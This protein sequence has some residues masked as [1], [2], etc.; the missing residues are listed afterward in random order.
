MSPRF[1]PSKM[2]H[3]GKTK[4]SGMWT[5]RIASLCLLGSVAV[6]GAT[7]EQLDFFEQRIRPVLANECYECHGPEKQKGGLRLDFRDGLLKGGDTGPALVPGNSKTS[8]LIQSIRHE[9]ADSE[10]PKKRPK[11]PDA[12]IADFAGWV[13]QGAL[14]P[15]DQPAPITTVSKAAEWGSTFEAR[16]DWW[17]FKP[18]RRS[19]V[20]AVKNAGW[21]DQPVDRF[22]LAKMEEHGLE[23]ASVADRRTLIRRVTYAL[24]GLPPTTEEIHRFL[25][26]AA[27]DAYLKVVDRL[28]ASP[29]FG[30]HWARHWMDLVRFAET[31]GSEGD[32]EIPNAWRYRDYLVRAFNADVPWDQLI[33][34]HLAGDLLAKPRLNDTEGIN[35]SL[36]GLAHFRLVEHGYNPVDTLD[37][38]VKTIDSQ[39]DV[40][41][42]AFQGLTVSCARCH[43]HKFDPIGQRDYYALQGVFGSVRPTQLTFDQPERLRVHRHELEALKAEIK[44]GL[45]EAWE[46]FAHRLTEDL[47]AR[48]RY[49]ATN[50][51]SIPGDDFRDRIGRLQQRV[52]EIDNLGRESVL[53][54]RGVTNANQSSVRPVAAWTFDG[55]ARDSVGGLAGELVGGAFV[56]DGRLI[57][58]GKEAYLRTAP[59]EHPLREKTLEVWAAPANLDQRGGGV[60][61]VES[62]DGSVFDSIVFAEK[63]PRRWMAGSEGFRRSRNLEGPDET[64][65]AGSLVHLVAVYR[66]SNSIAL[67]RDG[68]AYGAAYTASGEG[69]KLREFGAASARVLLGMRHT[70][71][72]S[73]FFAGEIEEARLYDRALEPDEVAASF[74][75]GPGLISP[76][77]ISQALTPDQRTVREGRLAEIAELRRVM[78]TRYPDYAERDA[79]RIRRNS[80]FGVAAKDGSH[81]LGV[82]SRLATNS[83]GSFPGE[84]RAM[85]AKR[86]EELAERR[87]FN[88]DTFRAAWDF[89]G[90]GSDGWF[91]YGPNPP[92]VAARPGEFTVQPEGDRILAGLLPAGVFSHRLSER[93]NGVFASPRFKVSSDRISVRVVGGKGARVRLIT[94]NYPIGQGNIFPQANLNS[95][96]PTWITLDTAYRR[97][98]M[99]YLELAT[100]EDV[101]SRDRS[102]A[103]PGGRSF[104]GVERVVF[105]DGKQPPADEG[106]A[107][108]VLFQG[109]P[110]AS[111]EDLAKRIGDR[112]VHAIEAWRRDSLSEGDR[113][114]LDAFI[115][116]GQL[117]G[118]LVDLPSV[119][120][121][122]LEYR[123][124]EGE[125]PLPR[126]VPGVVE[127]TAYDA[128]L[129][130][131]GDHRKPMDPVPRGY[132][133]LIDSHPYATSRSGR[134][135]LANDIVDPANPLTS[136][137]MVNRIWHCLF[138]RG[139][140]GT[141]D[142]FGR[143][144]EEPSHPEL[145]DFLAGHFIEHGWSGKELIRFLVTT[146]AYQLSSV[147]SE[148]SGQV[149]PA[150]EWLSHAR[151]RRLE[152]ESIRDSL[153]AISGRLDSTMFGPGA[154][155]LAM[156]SE[157]RRRSVYL[158]VKR[159]FPSPFLETFDAPKPFTTLG[160]RDAT[161]VP[162][163][164]LALLNDPFVVEQAARWAV[165]MLGAEL[166]PD[167][168]VQRMFEIAF[169]RPAGDAE[170]A[171]CRT[172]LDDLAKDHHGGEAELV[173]RD[174]GQSLFNLKE[175][176]YLR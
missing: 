8:L 14:D 78:A 31:H 137:V 95:D 165:S 171:L 109:G 90:K 6:H 77:A 19:A 75:A 44:S 79:E 102:P 108:T 172:Y 136:R 25:N 141:V 89:A 153:L 97:D 162:A 54:T 128:P 12:V 110:P 123:G 16:K 41:T 146:R 160:Q 63:E 134:L 39:I 60:L 2:Q 11:L 33:R 117:P 51:P 159:N 92:E 105:H 66:T 17:S 121:N 166:D 124:L 7:P 30:E 151:V 61:T 9:I 24:T 112:L 48:L 101:T 68:V 125:I 46:N 58:D 22:L 50:S 52:A 116:S 43:D 154:D 4:A 87:K 67:F 62:K 83:V 111:A 99:A 167:A 120:T 149:D 156:P 26:D 29:R 113:V 20:P 115:R 86:N 126:R 36:M 5:K 81:P 71:G 131:R 69:A 174:F 57:V 72:G 132:L 155:A 150:D 84:W 145:L 118:R 119:A 170:L 144:G 96:A 35:E 42:K 135:E 127:G 129:L 80:A 176:I 88:A 21:S 70:G 47:L 152:A 100:A 3:T 64:A 94:D 15:R 93:H 1:G 34:E 175:F 45:A 82:W 73:P 38:Q 169:A 98:S 28:L 140:V 55:D 147:A 32:P 104:F 10:M 103:G 23:P 49:G 56:R 173:W 139:L 130:S 65:S 37:E 114:F 18:I 142:N 122:V 163:Q 157:Q 13:D 107:G 138:G 161:N 85:S 168:R 27:P 76:D 53:R 143:L 91:R 158:T 59:L 164:S 148:R 106:D 133:E 74:R 40:V